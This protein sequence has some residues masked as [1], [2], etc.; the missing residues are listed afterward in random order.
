MSETTTRNRVNEIPKD[1]VLNKKVK[2]FGKG[3]V[4]KY[5][6]YNSYDPVKKVH[7]LRDVSVPNRDSITDP[8]TGEVYEIGYVKNFD[9]TGKPVFGE[10]WFEAT[11]LCMFTLHGGQVQHKKMYDYI[12]RCN[13]LSDNP[14]RDP[15]AKLLIERVEEDSDSNRLRD[16]RKQRQE[17][18]NMVEVMTDDEITTYIKTLKVP[19]PSSAMG[20]KDF[21]EDH[22]EKGGARKFLDGSTSKGGAEFNELIEFVKLAKKK[23]AISY[24]KSDGLWTTK[25]TSLVYK[26]SRRV[27][28]SPDKELAAYLAT[29]E[30]QEAKAQIEAFL[31]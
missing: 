27:G 24:S 21:L 11:G 2:P 7:L 8:D 16:L 17:A 13:F 3:D 18:L 20:R 15:S 1:S 22:I 9:P 12:E 25:D 19:M 23:E 29:D 10:V 6:L 26:G 14:H 28:G 4:A 30:G 31:K 5:R